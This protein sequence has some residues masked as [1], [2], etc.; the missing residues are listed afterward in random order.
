MER[1]GEGERGREGEGGREREG[2]RGREREGGREREREED[3]AVIDI[4]VHTTA[5]PASFSCAGTRLHL[6]CCGCHEGGV[7]IEV[8]VPH[9]LL[10]HWPAL[11]QGGQQFHTHSCIHGRRVSTEEV[12]GGPGGRV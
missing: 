5:D 2:E 4:H 11:R 9:Q 10:Q 6:A 7:A 12:I 1:K 3:N 8:L